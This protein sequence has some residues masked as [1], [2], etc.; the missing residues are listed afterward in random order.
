MENII[1]YV[2]LAIILGIILIPVLYGIFITQKMKSFKKHLKVGDVV[3][4][5]IGEDRSKYTVVSLG[6]IYCKIRDEFGDII[7]VQRTE[8]YPDLRTKYSPK[9]LIE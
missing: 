2:L 1:N 6:E 7:K 5:Y 4:Y 8:M 3:I 9:P